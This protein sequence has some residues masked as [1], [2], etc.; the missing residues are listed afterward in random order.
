[1]TK[2]KK[3][4]YEEQLVALEIELIRVHRWLQHTG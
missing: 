4:D 3:K 2:L 1:M